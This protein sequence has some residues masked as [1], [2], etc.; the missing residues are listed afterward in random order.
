LWS[1]ACRSQWPHERR[2]LSTPVTYTVELSHRIR[3]EIALRRSLAEICVEPG[4]PSERTVYQWRRTH[5]EFAAEYEEARKWRAEARA[6]FVT[7]RC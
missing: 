5:Q 4:F 2:L 3:E 6:D 7:M 1:E